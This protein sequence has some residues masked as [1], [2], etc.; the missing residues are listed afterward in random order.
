[1]YTA[2]P[3]PNNEFTG[4]ILFLCF[5][6]IVWL[7]FTALY[8]VLEG[9]IVIKSRINVFYCGLVLFI[10]GIVY[11]ISPPHVAP[12][13]EKVEVYQVGYGGQL[14]SAGGK[15]PRSYYQMYVFYQTPNDGVV[16]IRRAEGK[17]YPERAIL[18]KN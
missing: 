8:W 6:F 15:P 1:M 5:S 14:K 17:V 16:A 9:E 10:T 7:F 2:V 3:I 12:K 11:G 4:Y 18:Y 13:N